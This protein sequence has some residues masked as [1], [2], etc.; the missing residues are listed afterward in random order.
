MRI[1]VPTTGGAFSGTLTAAAAESVLKNTDDPAV[2]RSAFGVFNAW[3]AEN[4][5]LF[6]DLL[7]AVTAVRVNA[8]EASG[9]TLMDAAAADEGVSAAVKAAVGRT[10]CRP[11]ARWRCMSIGSPR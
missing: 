1:N 4:A 11:S 9:R 6:A 5:P 3:Y 7:N 10:N 8:L 2:R